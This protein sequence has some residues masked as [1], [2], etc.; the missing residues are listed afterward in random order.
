MGTSLHFTDLRVPP[1]W[2]GCR[3]PQEL[4]IRGSQQQ[5]WQFCAGQRHPSQAGQP[6]NAPLHCSAGKE[7]ILPAQRRDQTSQHLH[8]PNICSL[9][10]QP[11]Q[12]AKAGILGEQDWS[13]TSPPGRGLLHLRCDL[14]AVAVSPHAGGICLSSLASYPASKPGPPCTCEPQNHHAEPRWPVVLVAP[15]GHK[16]QIGLRA[17]GAA[18]EHAVSQQTLGV[19]TTFGP[20]HMSRV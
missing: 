3:W 14:W 11:R 16:K 20:F 8:H 9:G 5:L 4:V 2:V 18:A 10:V 1:G 6:Q 15:W 12:A 13:S 17:A 7:S 19:N